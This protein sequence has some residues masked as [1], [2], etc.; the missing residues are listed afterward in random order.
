MH[1]V[2]GSTNDALMEK[3]ASYPILFFETMMGTIQWLLGMLA[4][5]TSVA[6]K[7]VDG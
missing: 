1:T 6:I 4:S 7:G 3:V 5:A 2:R